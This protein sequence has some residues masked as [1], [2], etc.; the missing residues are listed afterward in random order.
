MPF[1]LGGASRQ[2]NAIGRGP[3]ALQPWATSYFCSVKLWGRAQARGCDG[4]LRL[5][6]NPSPVEYQISLVLITEENHRGLRTDK[7]MLIKSEGG[8]REK[9]GLAG[10]PR[11]TDKRIPPDKRNGR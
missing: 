5:R 4:A 8:R 10:L 3:T 11:R 2:A 9:D 6:P 7:L 1:A